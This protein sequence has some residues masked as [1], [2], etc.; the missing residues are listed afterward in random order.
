MRPKRQAEVDA[1]VVS[2]GYLVGARGHSGFNSYAR[3]SAFERRLQWQRT[4][5]LAPCLSVPAAIEFQARC[6]GPHRCMRCHEEAVAAL[7]A[8]TARNGLHPIAAD[9]R[10]AQMA[11]LPVRAS[12]AECLRVHLFWQHRAE[13]PVTQ[14]GG[15]T[16]VRVSVQA[17]NAPAEL[18]APIRALQQAGV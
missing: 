15:Q 3:K 13:V 7:R 4:R 14:H 10:F 9:G 11:T 16:F 12:D 2:W 1:T 5:D 8:V 18:D 17:Y 6:D